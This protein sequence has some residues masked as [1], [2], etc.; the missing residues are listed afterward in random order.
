MVIIVCMM[1]GAFCAA[2]G[3]LTGTYFGE[4]LNRRLNEREWGVEK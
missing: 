3:I 2:I 1:G 4:K